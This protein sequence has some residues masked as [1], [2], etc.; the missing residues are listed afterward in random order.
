MDLSG[1]AE[2]LT[3]AT[4]PWWSGLL[5]ILLGGVG[6]YLTTKRSDERRQ[7]AERQ[8]R[9]DQQQFDQQALSD[10]RTYDVE[11]QRR[12]DVRKAIAGLVAAS[13]KC[14][15]TAFSLAAHST[16]ENRR[17]SLVAIGDATYHFSQVQ[18]LAGGPVLMAALEL[19]NASRVLNLKPGVDNLVNN[20]GDVTQKRL[21][22]I[23]TAKANPAF[24]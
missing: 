1:L 4:A 6:T 13:A 3:S 23:Y 21:A 24:T 10:Q 12:A 8:T 5:G 2:F 17:E 15:Q 9:L 18:L 14:E 22:L 16:L 20:V 7:A 19:H 11:Q